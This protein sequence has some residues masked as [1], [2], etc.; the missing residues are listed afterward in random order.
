MLSCL[1]WPPS[2]RPLYCGSCW[3]LGHHNGLSVGTDGGLFG[4]GHKKKKTQ[5]RRAVVSERASE[6][7]ALSETWENIRGGGG[8]GETEKGF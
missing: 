4:R 1:L 5:G 7:P 2:A 8:R 3:A 6:Q